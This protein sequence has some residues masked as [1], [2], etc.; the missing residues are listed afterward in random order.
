MRSPAEKAPPPNPEFIRTPRSGI[1]HTH[2]VSVIF[3]GDLQPLETW[4]INTFQ[5]RAGIEPFLNLWLADLFGDA[6]KIKVKIAYWDPDTDTE[7]EP[8]FNPVPLWNFLLSP[9]DMIFV[10]T[11]Q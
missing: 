2:R 5:K 6:R 7:I 3:S 1:A 9:L 8:I 10:A 11:D 4:N